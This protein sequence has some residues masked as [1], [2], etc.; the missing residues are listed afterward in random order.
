MTALV[1]KKRGKNFVLY[2]NGMIRVDNVRF[3][4]PHVD[5]PWKKEGDQ[6][7][8][9]YSIT[10]M[11]PKGTHEEA[12]TA[13]AAVMKAV[14]AEAKISVPADKKF[15]RDG[16]AN[17]SD[18]DDENVEN[19]YAGHWFVNARESN[20][21]SLRDKAGKKLDPVEDLDTIKELFFG[22]A[23][24]HILLR[25]WVQ[26]NKFGKRLNAG[27]VAVMFS[28]EDTAFGQGRVDDAD[29]WDDVATAGGGSDDG[30]DDDDL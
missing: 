24:G 17:A 21:P 26:N 28:K 15:L 18:D 1:V 10:G 19:G 7:E 13:I 29:A 3:S 20:R 6:G 2:E 27:L 4:Y 23:W 11:M 16:D 30:D 25:P 5:K 14:L 22:G 9:K 8:A 12:K